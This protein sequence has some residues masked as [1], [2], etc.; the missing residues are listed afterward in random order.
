M[1]HT[2]IKERKEHIMQ[3]NKIEIV[4]IYNRFD[5]IM[6]SVSKIIGS[7]LSVNTALI[8]QDKFRKDES[9]YKPAL[10][11]V[12]QTVIDDYDN[13]IL[14]EY[15]YKFPDAKILVITLDEKWQH[16]WDMDNR[17]KIEVLNLWQSNP[18]LSKTLLVVVKNKLSETKDIR[19]GKYSIINSG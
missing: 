14:S 15:N 4:I 6:K 10:L 9:G 16:N 7:S 5:L 12:D 11:I 2:A 3:T 13:Q 19:N 1:L 8:H 18:S 17:E